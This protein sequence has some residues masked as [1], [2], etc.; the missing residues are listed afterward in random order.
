MNIA[1]TGAGGHPGG[2]LRRRLLDAGHSVTAI[3]MQHTAALEGLTC[4][5]IEANILDHK[6]LGSA[7]HGHPVVCHL[8]AQPVEE[9]VVDIYAWFRTPPAM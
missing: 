5:F 9:T 4:S 1:V 6:A 8:A 3:D 7:P 2:V